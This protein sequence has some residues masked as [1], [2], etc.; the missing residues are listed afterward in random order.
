MRSFI[1]DMEDM[2]NV[3][4]FDLIITPNSAHVT[5]FVSH[6]YDLSVMRGRGQSV[7]RR[8]FTG[9]PCLLFVFT[10]G[11]HLSVELITLRVNKV[12]DPF[13][14]YLPDLLI[15]HVRIFDRIMQRS[16]C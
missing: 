1:F 6:R 10:S 13:S 4:S 2:P 3:I 14:E 5:Q 11:E 8:L 9:M 16:R 12:R 7:Y 15:G